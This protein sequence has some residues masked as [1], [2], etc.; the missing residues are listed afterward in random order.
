MEKALTVHSVPAA[1]LV[2]IMA[3]LESDKT[4][5]TAGA[6]TAEEAC[7]PHAFGYIVKD[8]DKTV[9]AY[10]LAFQN[11]ARQRVCWIT[12]ARGRAPGRDL[13]AEIMPIIERQAREGGAH[14]IAITTKRLGLAKKICASG[15]VETGRT[16]RKSV[17]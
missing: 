1:A 6:V 9:M 14:Q 10:L 8:G 11:C 16:Y 2:N 17:Q 3:D 15:F 4:D 13:T 5:T 7:N 12:G